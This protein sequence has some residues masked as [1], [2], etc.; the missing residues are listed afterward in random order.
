MTAT[1]IMARF[2]PLMPEGVRFAASFPIQPWKDEEG[3]WH[4]PE[5]IALIRV[6]TVSHFCDGMIQAEDLAWTDEMFRE[7]I[8]A[9]M[10][11]T[12]NNSVAANG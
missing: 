6:A 7:R 1:D 8:L 5:N 10:L 11:G 2:Q 4:Q 3:N 12:L 9:P